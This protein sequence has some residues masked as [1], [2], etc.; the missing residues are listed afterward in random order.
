[1]EK[2]K[3]LIVDDELGVSSVIKK[4]FNDTFQITIETSAMKALEL[5]K[6]ERFDLFFVSYQLP[7]VNGI[8]VLE[9]I[10]EE[11]D[12]N[13][14]VAIFCTVYGT[15]HLFK[16]EICQSLFSFFI[17][18]PFEIEVLKQ[19]MRKAAM[20]LEQKRKHTGQPEYIYN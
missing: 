8:E 3:L 5:M 13:D 18:K 11:Y 10:K 17:E 14:Y 6:R 9:E 16:D 19:I 12:N 15:I 1:M 20:H 4:L 7:Y 2:L